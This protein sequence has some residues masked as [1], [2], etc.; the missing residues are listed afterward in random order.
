MTD[1][2][3]RYVAALAAHDTDALLGLFAADVDFRAM[4]PGQ[5]W[6]AQ[7]PDEVVQQ[8]LYQW[9]DPS[10]EIES[11]EQAEVGSMA[12]RGRV[13]YR[14]RIRNRDGVVV[15]TSTGPSVLIE[16]GPT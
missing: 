8:V 9:L 16:T 3:A 5:F 10:D 11:V 15:S 4:T 13:D 2:G 1:V 6:E 7:S 12:D 14:F